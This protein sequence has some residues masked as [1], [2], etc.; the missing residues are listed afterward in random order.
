MASTRWW[1][2]EVVY[3]VY[4]R[5]FQ[6]TNNDGIGDLNGI[7]AHLDYLKDLG[8]TTIW[9]SPVYKSPMVDM[10]YDISDYQAIDPQFG[11]M[12]DFDHLLAEAKKRGMKIIMDL[13]VN[14]TSDQ[15]DWFQQALADPQ[16]KYRDYYIFKYSDDG[17]VPNNWRSIFG[18]STWTEVPSEP[19]T[20]YFH[21]FAP[22][23]PDLNWENPVLREEI[24]T[25]INWWL[26]KGISGFRIDAITHLKKDLD[27]A[28]IEPDGED[29]LANVVKK[30]QNRPGL[31]A[32]LTEL[33]AKTFD[34][35]NAMTVGEAYG[36][37]AADMPKFIGPDGY[38]SMIFDFS[39][40][41]IEVNNVDEWYRGRSN[42]QVKDL[43]QLLFE[44]QR[45][46]KTADGWT[47]NVIENHDQSRAVSKWIKNPQYQTPLAAKALATMYYFLR[48]IPFIYQGQELG[49]K[50]FKRT[51]IN[52]F[53][54]LSSVNN[55][56]MGLKLG[57]DPEQ[58]LDLVN[59]KSR[60]NARVP[61]QWTGDQFG[62]FSDHEPWLAMGNDRE[63]IN[64]M[65]ENKDE[66]SVLNYYR[67]LNQM[68]QNERYQDVI[69]NGELEQLKTPDNVVGYQ[70]L[71]DDQELVVFVNLGEETE[72]INY[73]GNYELVL[74]NSR[75]FI[76]MKP[77][78]LELQP[79][80]AVVLFN[81]G[82]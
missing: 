11:T 18:G 17:Q 55:Y 12:A 9:V 62:D 52:Q 28:S 60:D 33:K 2:N 63:A 23:Q 44:S 66:N 1:K 10:G 36:V 40:F 21:T 6:D 22:Q 47:A 58:V 54:D 50:N 67:K 68:R 13:V 82:K 37:P 77:E 80:E 29:G 56:K 42:W 79:Y 41:N 32:F 35:Y 27:W 59:F 53:N 48:G 72:T 30:G 25:M 7:T 4:P 78:Q 76:S 5:S 61:M 49:A 51:N 14:H 81:Q 65:D 19:G 43:K 70:R 26:A 34:K 8:V 3:Q 69:V 39:Y 20:Y 75:E 71:T 16:S 64:V 38:F 45:S 46:I 57:M 74:T 24:Y 73:T 31:G 15:H